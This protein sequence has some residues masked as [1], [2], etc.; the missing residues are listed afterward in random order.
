ML[1]EATGEHFSTIMHMCTHFPSCYQA[2][3][4]ESFT[5]PRERGTGLR[6]PD[7]T[8]NQ[9]YYQPIEMKF[10]LSHYIHKSMPDAKFACGS[11]S[12]FGDMTS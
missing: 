7:V 12:N 1:V 10:C 6:G 9:S 11:F 3:P 2:W 8:K 4:F 5:R